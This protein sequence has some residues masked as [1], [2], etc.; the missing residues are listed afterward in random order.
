MMIFPHN[1]GL[2][3]LKISSLFP[4][5]SL[6]TG[7]SLYH[8]LL[9]ALVWHRKLFVCQEAIK[10]RR[11]LMVLSGLACS[12][13]LTSSSRFR[14]LIVACN[15]IVCLHVKIKCSKII[16]SCVST[17]TNQLSSVFTYLWWP[18]MEWDIGMSPPF[19]CR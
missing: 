2:P 10:L 13:S 1:S 15:S 9:L 4:R 5:G 19:S 16:I 11:R 6:T 17:G 12:S 18:M 3:C 8:F 7:Q 14:P